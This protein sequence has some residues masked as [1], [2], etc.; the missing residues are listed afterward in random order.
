LA[1]LVF[2]IAVP[3]LREL[4]RLAPVHVDDLLLIVVVAAAALLMMEGVKRI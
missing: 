1:T 3:P 2:V 4:F